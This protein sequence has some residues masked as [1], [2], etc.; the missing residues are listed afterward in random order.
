[1]SPCQ[2]LTISYTIKSS[3]I[4][5]RIYL[6]NSTTLASTE[7]L[8]SREEALRNLHKREAERL[9]E[10]TKRFPPLVV[11]NHVRIQNQTRL[12]PLKWDSTGVAIEVRQLDQ[13]VI[14]VDGSG[15]VTLCNRKFLRKYVYIP[16]ISPHPTQP[17][18]ND[19][20][21]RTLN[22]PQQ[23]PTC[24]KETSKSERDTE[25]PKQDPIKDPTPPPSV[26][27]ESPL[28][29]RTLF[30]PTETPKHP[31]TPHQNTSGPF[32]KNSYNF[33]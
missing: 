18:K 7:T 28:P 17:I 13:Y 26:L 31:T 5:T 15:R 3:E 2:H 11:G 10:H 30:I 12:S 1:M 14:R 6:C 32:H 20:S 21:S 29:T 4:K 8:L 33:S 27:Q 24:T 16:V 25:N 9:T 19:L 22:A 23:E